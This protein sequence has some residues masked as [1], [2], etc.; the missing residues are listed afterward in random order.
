MGSAYDGNIRKRDLETDTPYNTYTRAGLPPTPIA[1]P[2]SAA[3]EAAAHPGAGRRAVFRRPRRRQRRH[4]VLAGPRRAQ[5]ARRAAST[6]CGAGDERRCTRGRASSR[7]KAA[8]A[9]A[10]PPCSRRCARCCRR[11][12]IEV[13]CTR[14]PGGTPLAEA[15]REL[16]LDPRQGAVRRNRTAADVRL[17]RAAGARDD[18]AG[19]A[20]RRLGGQRPLHR[21]QLRLPG[22]RPRR[23]HRV[24]SPSSSAA[25]SASGRPDLP[26]RRAGRCRPAARARSRGASPTAS[27]ASSDDFFERVRA[28]YLARAAAEPAALPRDRCRAAARDA[29][30]AQAS[31]TCATALDALRMSALRALA[32]ARLRRRL[33]A[34]I[35]AGRLGHALLFCGPAQLGKREVA[36]RARAAPAVHSSAGADG[37]APA[38]RAAAAS[39][40]GGRHASRTSSSPVVRRSNEEGDTPAHRD[41][42]STRSAQ[43]SSSCR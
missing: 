4:R 42:R 2:G 27:S 39:L 37:D 28:A 23:R 20:A 41:R 34:A 21:C 36:E 7:S 25:R 26:A 29:V 6:S 32:A 19:A 5:N 17:A 40:L 13:V 8:R 35:D 3:L 33:A 9:P 31:R 24:S 12:G 14:E 38:A 15:I 10:S 1:M 18:P 22:R 43:L 16:L 30:A 11:S